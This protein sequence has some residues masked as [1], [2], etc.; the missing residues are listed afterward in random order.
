[1]ESLWTSNRTSLARVVENLCTRNWNNECRPALVAINNL[2]KPG[3]VVLFYALPRGPVRFKRHLSYIGG[4][5]I[6]CLRTEGSPLAIVA[7]VF[8]PITMYYFRAEN[9]NRLPRLAILV[10]QGRRL[11]DGRR[12][13]DSTNR[14]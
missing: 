8:G 2:H 14:R 9:G 3:V 7:S 4:C 6:P 1:M 13:G 11:A 12:E 10:L 5:E